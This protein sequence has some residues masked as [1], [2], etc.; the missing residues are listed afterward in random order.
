MN[1]RLIIALTFLLVLAALP[2]AAYTRYDEC[3]GHWTR[4]QNPRLTF[5]LQSFD[6]DYAW[7]AAIKEAQEAWTRNARGAL[8]GLT[9]EYVPYFET[10]GLGNGKNEIRIADPTMWSGGT[11]PA[12]TV[13]RWSHC[14][15][16]NPFDVAHYIEV[17]VVLNPYT[18]QQLD[19][20]T[21]PAPADNMKNATMVMAHEFGH[22]FGLNHEDAYLARMN[23]GWPGMKG[24]PVS[25]S[26]FVWVLG[27]D[28]RGIRAAYGFAEEQRDLSP[29]AVYLA[30]PGVAKVLPAPGWT[31]RNASL[32]FPFT[33]HNLGTNNETF[34]VSFYLTPAK[35]VNPNTS[36]FLGTTTV[37]LLAGKA[38]TGNA[39]VF[40]PA[41]APSG[42]QYIAWFT[43]PTNQIPEFH[44]SNNG[45][46][47]ASATY[48]SDA[49]KPN[50]CFTATPTSGYVPL[51][52]SFDAGCTTDADGG[53]LT[54][55]WDFGYGS[56]ASGPTVTHFYGSA[57]N[58]VATLTV[59]D[60][61]GAVSQTSQYIS[62]SCNQFCPDEPY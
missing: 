49:R 44:E 51:E 29:A 3:H 54:Y 58:F 16:F 30:S 55:T 14:S 37:S 52:V 23:S 36:Y 34:N 59:T 11:Q 13:H 56:T 4:W 41:D 21:N 57:N 42:Y 48:I 39:T 15:P 46:T 24:G 20:S 10:Y 43:D 2:A 9:M 50:A 26:N 22:V 31:F 38:V 1:R 18:L 45:V 53:P 7:R 8:I 35:S 25:V 27:D 40:I 28:S 19:T 6:F 17:D 60:Q 47:F 12:T 32:S 33:V 61:Y 5:Q 62:V